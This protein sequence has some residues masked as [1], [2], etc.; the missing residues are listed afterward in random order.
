MTTHP[1]THTTTE[2][3]HGFPVTERKAF[4]LETLLKA[5]PA[6]DVAFR[7]RKATVAKGPSELLPGDRSD[8]SWISTE[9]PDRASEVV[10]ARGMNDSQFKLNPIVTLQHA[11]WLPPVGRSLWRK[12]VRD[13]SRQG[14]KAKTHYPN[15]PDSWQGA[16]P[17]DVALSL[18]QA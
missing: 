14:V 4:A 2:G 16:W 10:L 11:Y 17:A 18:V 3:P 12:V 1:L 8:V 7:Y 5:L 13:G 15:R 9:D 6:A